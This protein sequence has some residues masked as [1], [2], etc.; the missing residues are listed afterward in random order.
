M[1]QTSG[2]DFFLPWSWNMPPCESHPPTSLTCKAAKFLQFVCLRSYN[3]LE[4]P[5]APT[6]LR[7]KLQT[8]WP[9]TSCIPASLQTGLP[10]SLLA[11]SFPCKGW[12]TT[13]CV[14]AGPPPEGPEAAPPENSHRIPGQG[15]FR[16]PRWR[17]DSGVWEGKAPLATQPAR[18]G[19]GLQLRALAAQPTSWPET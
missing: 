7:E 15:E 3:C 1:T 17:P 14:G 6:F 12:E 16:P 11:C 2:S 5:M 18:A 13:A 10:I 8:P 9:P 4:P 19:P